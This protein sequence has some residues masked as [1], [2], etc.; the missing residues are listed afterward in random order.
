NPTCRAHAPRPSNPEAVVISP[1]CSRAADAVPAEEAIR[2]DTGRYWPRDGCRKGRL[3]GG[4]SSRVAAVGP[5]G[6]RAP[7]RIGPGG[8]PGGEA[9]WAGC[10]AAITRL[11][12]SI[13]AVGRGSLAG[14]RCPVVRDRATDPIRP[15]EGWR[16]CRFQLPARA[17]LRCAY[18]TTSPG[19]K[20]S[21]RS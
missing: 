19:A 5:A 20:S 10:S 14:R 15:N 1:S 11:T 4:E 16:P 18:P 13:D 8:G 12:L 21:A 9:G 3:A 17:A 2:R 6:G 7:S